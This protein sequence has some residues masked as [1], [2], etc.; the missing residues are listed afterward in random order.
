MT[1]DCECMYCRYTPQTQILTVHAEEKLT[2]PTWIVLNPRLLQNLNCVKTCASS[3][4]N[5]PT[6]LW[7]FKDKGNSDYIKT[8][9]LTPKEMFFLFEKNSDLC[10]CKK[11]K[12]RLL[13]HLGHPKTTKFS[14]DLVLVYSS[15]QRATLVIFFFGLI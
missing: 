4:V 8:Y 15:V 3:T 12:F 9:I 10:C 14:S 11:M 13:P 1:L 7:M 5:H 2:Q 6:T